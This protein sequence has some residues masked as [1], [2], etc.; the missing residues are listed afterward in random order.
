MQWRLDLSH[1][2]NGDLVTLAIALVLIL[3]LFLLLLFFQRKYLIQMFKISR[4]QTDV[5]RYER[6]TAQAAQQN[7]ESREMLE[8]VKQIEAVL[9][10]AREDCSD[11]ERPAQEE[12][13]ATKPESRA[14]TG[15]ASQ[16]G[17]DC[18]DPNPRAEL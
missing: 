2:T 3:I 13:R 1:L 8:R 11:P 4:T 14:D 9:A 17:R 10:P 6:Q 16:D 18:A 5:K 7:A 12:A 15:G